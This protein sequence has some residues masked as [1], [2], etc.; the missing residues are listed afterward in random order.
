MQLARVGTYANATEANLVKAKLASYGIDA[1]VEE[2]AGSTSLPTF[3]QIVGVKVFVRETDLAEAYE[4]L[5]RML[6][7]GEDQPTDQ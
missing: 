1:L 4:V 2:D 7:S 6:T 5:E 3:E